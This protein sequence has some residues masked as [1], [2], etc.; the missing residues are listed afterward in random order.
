MLTFTFFGHWRLV[1]ESLVNFNRMSVY[2]SSLFVQDA[3]PFTAN[4]KLFY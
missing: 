2:R 1:G 4:F 3:D